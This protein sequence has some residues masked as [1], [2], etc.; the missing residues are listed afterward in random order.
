[1]PCV[2]DSCIRGGQVQIAPLP[3]ACFF[4]TCIVSASFAMWQSV[5]IWLRVLCESCRCVSCCGWWGSNVLHGDSFSHSVS[6]WCQAWIERKGRGRQSL[7][8]GHTQHRRTRISIL[9]F[10][11]FQ[12]CC[13]WATLK[14]P[15]RA[16]PPVGAGTWSRQHLDH[17]CSVLSVN[18]RASRLELR[19]RQV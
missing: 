1:M 18:Y 13:C 9:S 12:V 19:N 8:L 14:E 7:L 17:L 4:L 10:P 11:F 16:L 15:A 3:I 6:V 2:V 5:E